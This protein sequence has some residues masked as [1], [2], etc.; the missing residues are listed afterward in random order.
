MSIKGAY[1]TTGHFTDARFAPIWYHTTA[2]GA[3]EW[4]R[5]RPD[6]FF[7]EDTPSFAEYCPPPW[8]AGTIDWVIPLAWGMSNAESVYDRSGVVS[9]SF[10]QVFAISPDGGIRIDKFSQWIHCDTNGV[11]THSEGIR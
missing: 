11:V 5:I 1:F 8:S 6:N 4:H 3:G 2:R 10:H 9:T 7:F